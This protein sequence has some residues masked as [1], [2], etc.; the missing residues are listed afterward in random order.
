MSPLVARY[1]GICKILNKC[2]NKQSPRRGGVDA[3]LSLSSLLFFLNLQ[4]LNTVEVPD[5]SVYS[6]L[7]LRFF[8]FCFLLLFILMNYIP[9]YYRALETLLYTSWIT[10]SLMTFRKLAL[11]RY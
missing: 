8:F 11:S 9:F 10:L 2:T 1:S 3:L 7:C 6:F 4:I 5:I